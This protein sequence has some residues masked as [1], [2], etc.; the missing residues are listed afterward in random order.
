M[1]SSL[2]PVT[3]DLIL[4]HPRWNAAETL[5]VLNAGDRPKPSMW[6]PR[7]CRGTF[8]LA[9][10]VQLEAMEVNAWAPAKSVAI[11]TTRHLKFRRVAVLTRSTVSNAQYTRL[12]RRAIIAA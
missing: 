12:L 7:R 10:V 3:M 8:P 4:I 5:P 1:A 11:N 2:P 9:R 6:L